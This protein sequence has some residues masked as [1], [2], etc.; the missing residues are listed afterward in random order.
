MRNLSV[1]S[2]QYPQHAVLA[3]GHRL[4]AVRVPLKAS[5]PLN[6]K[7]VR[8]LTVSHLAGPFLGPS[9]LLPGLQAACGQETQ[10][11]CEVQWQKNFQKLEQH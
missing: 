9:V 10:W 6:L 7:V 5:P 3:P 11:G 1:S 4:H 2:C 8:A